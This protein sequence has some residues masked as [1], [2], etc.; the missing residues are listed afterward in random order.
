MLYTKPKNIFPQILY[1]IKFQGKNSCLVKEGI[2][3]VYEGNPGIKQIVFP[4]EQLWLYYKQM[5]ME[6]KQ[7][8]VNSKNSETNYPG[9][10]RNMFPG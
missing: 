5:S 1:Y 3:V 7:Y 6:G 9:N 8:K 4:W 2:K 10:W